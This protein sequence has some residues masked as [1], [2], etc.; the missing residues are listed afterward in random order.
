MP[1]IEPEKKPEIPVTPSTDPQPKKPDEVEVPQ[2]P[3]PEIDVP[4]PDQ[5]PDAQPE[6]PDPHF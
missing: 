6:I 4:L 2:A 5:A 3:K 1:G